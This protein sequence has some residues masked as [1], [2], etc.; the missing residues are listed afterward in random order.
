MRFPWFVPSLRG[1]AVARRA[2]RAGGSRTPRCRPQLESLDGRIVPSRTLI[3]TNGVGLPDFDLGD[4][5][6]IYGGSWINQDNNAVARPI[7][8]DNLIFPDD[9][10]GGRV[11][12]NNM[13]DLVV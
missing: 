9:A 8:G 2:A 6:L 7:N 4:P 5:P 3:W 13:S 1:D 11:I 10:V 12:R